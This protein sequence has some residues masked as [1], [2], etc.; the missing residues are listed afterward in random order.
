M[1]E[2][3]YKDEDGKDTGYYGSNDPSEEYGNIGNDFQDFTSYYNSFFNPITKEGNEKWNNIGVLNLNTYDKITTLPKLPEN[4]R[5]LY[6]SNTNIKNLTNFPPTI[7]VFKYDNV[8]LILL[9]SNVIRDI[10]ESN[11][12]EKEK[13]IILN[14]QH[15]LVIKYIDSIKN[16]LLSLNYFE[17]DNNS[18]VYVYIHSHGL[19]CCEI[20]NIDQETKYIPTLCELTDNIHAEKIIVVPSNCINIGSD[21]DAIDDITEMF[22]II[23]ENKDDIEQDKIINGLQTYLSG[24]KV[25]SRTYYAKRPKEYNKDVENEY[26][27]YFNSQPEQFNNKVSCNLYYE[28]LFNFESCDKLKRFG[29]Y[30]INMLKLTEK[31]I[32]F[33]EKTH[34]NL[35]DSPIEFIIKV[36]FPNKLVNETCTMTEIFELLKILGFKFIYIIDSSCDV[37]DLNNQLAS[38]EEIVKGVRGGFKKTKNKSNKKSKKGKK[39]KKN[40]SKKNKK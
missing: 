26:S 4:L 18:N 9:S 24:K 39:S 2:L 19:K 33:F 20:T 40:K 5:E 27:R 16:E 6:I 11:I 37:C 28:K 12:P 25:M 22:D 31:Q 3:V 34:I 35:L 14:D 10:K 17:G 32:E 15:N 29:L 7:K 8:K 13:I 1:N 23:E 30:I 21:N 38:S 36:L